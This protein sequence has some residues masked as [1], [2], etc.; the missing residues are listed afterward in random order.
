MATSKT[1]LKEGDNLPPRGKA[2]KTLLL[3]VI[4]DES[5]LSLGK[6]ATKEEA[7]RAFIHHIAKRAFNEAD[8]NSA[9][10]LKELITK[11]YPSLKPTLDTFKFVFPSDGTDT[12]KALSILESIAE[13]N[14]PPD[15]G[16]LIVSVIKDSSVIEANTDLKERIEQLEAILNDKS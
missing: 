10:L 2:F 3:E 11:S 16:Q 12:Q 5:M 8:P 7:N 13:G 1:T 14:L 15:V 4:K 9:M 6:G